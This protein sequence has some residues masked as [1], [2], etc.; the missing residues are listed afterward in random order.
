M[1][2]TPT[3]LPGGYQSWL[4]AAHIY[5]GNA[6]TQFL[7]HLLYLQHLMHMRMLR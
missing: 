5:Y 4:D 2:V 7:L 6:H 3:A 1:L